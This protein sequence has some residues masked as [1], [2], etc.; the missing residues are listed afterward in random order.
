MTRK[1]F[2]KFFVT[3]YRLILHNENKLETVAHSHVTLLGL[4]AF[5]FGVLVFFVA[6]SFV[7]AVYSPLRN[8]LPGYLNSDMRRNLAN[9]N[10]KLDSLEQAVEKQNLYITNIQDIFNGK[11]HVDSV[12]SIDSLTKVRSAELMYHTQREEKFA[13]EFEQKEK[14]NLTSQAAAVGEIQ[15]LTLFAPVH[16]IVTTRFNSGTGHYGVDITT[17]PDQGVMAILDGTVMMSSYTTVDRSVIAIQHNQDLVSVYRDCGTL[18]KKVGDK[19]QAGEVIAQVGE[20]EEK[21]Q[22]PKEGHS[23]N[24]KV[25]VELWYKGQPL[26]PNLYIVF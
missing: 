23:Q 15:G 6:I 4:I 7:I 17:N 16:G 25:H 1:E 18:Y 20:E 26:D 5:F 21:V 9:A 2:F 13:Q 22:K 10:L 19:V 3:K 8:Y 11:V 12:V 14:Y 24:N